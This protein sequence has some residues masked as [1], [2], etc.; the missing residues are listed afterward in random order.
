[1]LH[2]KYDLTKYAVKIIGISFSYNKTSQNELNFRM[3]ISKIQAVLELWRMWRLLLEGKFVVFKLLAISKIV[4][5][6]LLR[7]VPNNIVEE[8]I[9]IQKSFYGTSQLLK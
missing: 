8:L 3:T 9:K 1:M 5:L 7:S 4:Y 2:E 6:S